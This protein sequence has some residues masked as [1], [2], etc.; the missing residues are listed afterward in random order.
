SA[1]TSPRAPDKFLLSFKSNDTRM[2]V[3]RATVARLA[4]ELGLNETQAI[5]YALK[6]LASEILPA[7]EPDEGLPTSKE[8]RAIQATAGGRSGKRVVSSLF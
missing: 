1:M 4:E 8:L 2:G 5:H 7:Y 6:R 3:T